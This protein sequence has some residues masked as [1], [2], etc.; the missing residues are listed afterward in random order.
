V[1][2]ADSSLD[3]Q[4]DLSQQ[5]VL[6]VEI[7]ICS[8]FF[9]CAQGLFPSLRYTVHRKRYERKFGGTVGQAQGTV[10]TG[11][12]RSGGPGQTEGIVPTVLRHLLLR[13]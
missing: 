9:L 7:V 4:N 6:H 11:T 10:P 1:G 8:T 12:F 5:L 3:A 13:K 2:R